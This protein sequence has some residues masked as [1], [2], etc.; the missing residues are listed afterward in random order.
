MMK[1]VRV[2]ENV[3]GIHCRLSEEW[4]GKCQRNTMKTVKQIQ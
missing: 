1:S 3:G 2:C 4:D